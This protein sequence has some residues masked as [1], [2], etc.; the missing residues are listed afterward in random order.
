MG[1]AVGIV[2]YGVVA[3]ARVQ[4]EFTVLLL[5]SICFTAGMASFLRLSPVAVCFIAGAILANLPGQWREQ[6]RTALNHLERPIYLVFLALAGALW[7]VREWQG[8][9]LMGLLVVSRFIGKWLAV[10][11]G[12][13][14]GPLRLEPSEQRAL[15][16]APMGA[17]SIAIVLTAQDL[18][19]GPTIPWIVTAVIGGSMVTEIAVQA[20]TRSRPIENAA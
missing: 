4:R 18:Y 16:V 6:V 12:G 7:E 9:A 2:V 17:L 1:A 10:R 19:S 11:I 8:W 13:V 20:A 5:G 15:A 3:V 14:A